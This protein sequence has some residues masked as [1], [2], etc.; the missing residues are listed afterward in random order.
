VEARAREALR[1][2]AARGRAVHVMVGNR[3]FLL[4]SRFLAAAGAHAVAD[5]TMLCAFGTRLVVTHGDLLCTRDVAYQRFRRV[6][7]QPLLQR[8]FGTLPRG[9][10]ESFGRSTRA[11]SRGHEHRAAPDSR[12]DVDDDTTLA[13]LDAIG[14]PRL[15]H[16]HTHKPASHE[17]AGGRERLVLAD[18]ELDHGGA[19][20]GDI[21]RWT[22]HGLERRPVVQTAGA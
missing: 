10:R 1:Q 12:Y 18:W 22:A 20:R 5:P 2:A 8:L 15:L 7:R 13:W 17:L 16:G 11:Q 4:G 14:A 3:D 19:P 9:L 6:V 21:V